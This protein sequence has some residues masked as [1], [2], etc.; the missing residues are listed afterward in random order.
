M[1]TTRKATMADL[2]AK[3]QIEESAIPG[4]GYLYENRHFY[5][6]GV[7]NQGEMILAEL[8]GVPVGMGQ[9]SVLPDGSGWLETLRVTPEY[10][11]KGVGREIYKK[12]V[13]LAQKYNCPSMAM[14]TGVNNVAS[15][16]LAEAFGLKTVA[17]HRGYHLTDPEG[18]D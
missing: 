4:Y 2:E 3:L 14:F 8:D 16:A 6:D 1:M 7:E 5:F 15:S 17:R 11:R 18:G 10:Q 13:E 9:Y 12:Y